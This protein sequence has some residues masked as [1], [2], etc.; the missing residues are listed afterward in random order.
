MRAAHAVQN[1]SAAGKSAE[2]SLT[3][4]VGSSVA[5]AVAFC[6]GK[7]ADSELKSVLRQLQSGTASVVNPGSITELVR[8]RSAQVRK[9]G[10]SLPPHGDLRGGRLLVYFPEQQRG[11]VDSE[12]EGL[13]GADAAPPCD[14]W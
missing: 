10:I 7:A 9:R 6:S 8:E 2:L 13:F 12:T 5:D 3:E 14:T 11:R 1:L 4:W